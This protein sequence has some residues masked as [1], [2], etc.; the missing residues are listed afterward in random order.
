MPA[1][2]CVGA[3]RQDSL[4]AALVEY[5]ARQSSLLAVPQNIVSLTR[6]AQRQLSETIAAAET[7]GVVTPLSFAPTLV[8]P[9]SPDLTLK[10]GTALVVDTGGSEAKI[11]LAQCLRGAINF[12]S[13]VR[14]PNLSLPHA[15][16]DSFTPAMVELGCQAAR[17]LV[18]RG[19]PCAAISKFAKVW[20]NALGASEF[21]AG[22]GSAG[23]R[24]CVIDRKRAYGK[25]RTEGYT[26]TLKDGDDLSA[27]IDNA[28]AQGFRRVSGAPSF[29]PTVSLIAND[30]AAVLG[31]VMGA[32]AAAVNSTGTNGLVVHRG[33]GFN[34]ELGA[35]FI[36]P[37]RLLAQADKRF[38]PPG[39]R[40]TLET[41]TAGK[42]AAHILCG[43]FVSFEEG[44]F[45]QRC[46]EAISLLRLASAMKGHYKPLLE[47]GTSSSEWT[48]YFSGPELSTIQ[49]VNSF[50]ELRE[51]ASALPTL[52]SL[53]QSGTLLK[54]SFSTL[55]S[56]LAAQVE[57]A[58]A[59]HGLIEHVIA[60]PHLVDG[61]SKPALV[62][63]DSSQERLLPGF[64]DAAA[65][66]LK[67]LHEEL[68]PDAQEVTPVLCRPLVLQDAE[69]SVPA[70]GMARLAFSY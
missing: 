57:R 66:C 1:V 31:A 24:G 48:P 61:A 29:E 17:A 7:P 21:P 35:N 16:D 46:S 41:F 36:I 65:R 8:R 50:A 59:L 26:R 67:K 40:N 12:T 44:A 37:E 64:A 10:D 20:S 34:L 49:R 70:Q 19:I 52:S 13:L 51:Q 38:L 22:S 45:A 68:A 39:Q 54:S 53:L 25:V 69:V 58:G 9:L 33:H 30:T 56:L 4:S 63:V 5:I 14:V 55:K 47:A 3:G 23:I 28:F 43:Q 6:E 62:A 42:D 27:L 32:L 18:Q 60:S 11:F 15:G 2:V